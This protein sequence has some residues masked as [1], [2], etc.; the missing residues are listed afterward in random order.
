MSS[1]QNWDDTGS[2]SKGPAAQLRA[3]RRQ[4][5]EDTIQQKELLPTEGEIAPL[6]GPNEPA[7]LTLHL[8]F[9]QSTEGH[10]CPFNSVC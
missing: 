7:P 2:M 8:L 3:V 10:H 4:L 9:T 6:S 1:F 5:C